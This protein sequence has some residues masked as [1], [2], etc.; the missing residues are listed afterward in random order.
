M[1][2]IAG[3]I[4]AL[5]QCNAAPGPAL[6]VGGLFGLLGALVGASFGRREA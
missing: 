1:G 3:G 6:F 4:L 5:A 2:F